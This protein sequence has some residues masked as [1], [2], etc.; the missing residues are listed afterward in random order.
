MTSVMT[1][2]T[3]LYHAFKQAYHLDH[4][5]AAVHCAQVRYSPL[6]FR[7]AEQLQD[8]K[9]PDG[10]LTSEVVAVLKDK[11]AYVEDSGR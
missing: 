4:S 10:T 1:T 9:G 7:L 5:N 11:G 2:E 6:T 8:I 3:V